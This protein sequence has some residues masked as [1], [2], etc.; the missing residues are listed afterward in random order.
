MNATRIRKIAVVVTALSLIVSAPA[1][2]QSSR[3]TP[4]VIAT[5]N[6]VAGLAQ[7]VE[8]RAPGFA[9]QTVS[10]S[11]ALAGSM[12]GS[13]SVPINGAGS[14]SAVWTPNAAGAWT[15]SGTGSFASATPTTVTAAAVPTS[16][17]LLAP[18]SLVGSPNTLI[19]YVQSKSG[20]VIPAGSV[21]FANQFGGTLGTVPLAPSGPG[22]SSA[23]FAWT[24][25]SPAVYPISATYMPTVGV[26]GVVSAAASSTTNQ[27]PATQSIPLVTLR[28]PGVFVVGE[29]TQLAANISDATLQGSAAFINNTGGT[30]TG[31]SGSLPVSDGI[32]TV[33]WTP[34]TPGIQ[35]L[36]VQ[37]S[38]S[39]SN[40]SAQYSQAINVLPSPQPD[41][42]S[43]VPSGGSP[44]IVGA[45]ITL[46]ANQSVA[47][48]IATGSG[49]PVSISE[50]GPCLVN[51]TTIIA[52][53]GAATCTITVA[54]PGGGGYAPNS[55][56]FTINVTAPTK[57][58]P[59]S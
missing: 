9:N 36:I 47:L 23:V 13:V 10:I 57:G 50:S 30:Q 29:T 37:F 1:I 11:L 22:T 40:A 31:I 38:A 55:A 2:A 19:A 27:V 16:T 33:N 43:V 56:S 3:S 20:T 41:P 49:A 15:L 8:V 45:P 28:L 24:P 21:T 17:I 5:A 51:G 48:A 39:N 42:M 54:S 52:A 14:G 59:R 58:K 32:V 7:T 26:G 4:A 18:T 53:T 35:T 44:L 34:T 12:I 25:P 6:G 46:S